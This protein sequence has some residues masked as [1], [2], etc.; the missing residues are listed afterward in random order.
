MLSFKK[1]QSSH[2]TVFL[3]FSEWRLP[4]VCRC[5]SI[6]YYGGL[7]KLIKLNKNI[8]EML[9]GF[10]FSFSFHGHEVRGY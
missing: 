2:I 4:A 7:L 10:F 8:T 1:N 3:L 9:A 5:S 6:F